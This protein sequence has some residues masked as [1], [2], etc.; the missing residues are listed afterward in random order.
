MI[1][2]VIG[3]IPLFGQYPSYYFLLG[4][5]LVSLSVGMYGTTAEQ[6][7]AFYAA[8]AEACREPTW[9]LEMRTSERTQR[10]KSRYITVFYCFAANCTLLAAIMNCTDLQFT[11]CRGW[12]LSNIACGCR[13]VLELVAPV[14]SYAAAVA[15]A[16]ACTA[17]V[18]LVIVAKTKSIPLYSNN[19]FHMVAM[20]EL[21]MFRNASLGNKTWEGEALRTGGRLLRRRLQS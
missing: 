8:C 1:F 9:L 7:A 18:W 6:S 3:A 20:N 13:R 5:L 4:A 10:L 11:R 15:I 12:A 21:P 16:L 17:T 2:T 19:G 14:A